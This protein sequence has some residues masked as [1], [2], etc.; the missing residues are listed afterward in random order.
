VY[1]QLY[2]DKNPYQEHKWIW[3]PIELE[4]FGYKVKGVGIRNI[5][6]EKGLVSRLPKIIRPLC[7][8]V[9]VLTGLFTYFYPMLAGHVVCVKNLCQVHE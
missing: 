1:K 4:R 2:L 6:G 5:G 3:S 9:W 7:H 8:I